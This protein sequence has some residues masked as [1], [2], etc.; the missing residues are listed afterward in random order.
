VHALIQRRLAE[1][2]EKL[3]DLRRVRSTLADG[4]ERCRNP[5]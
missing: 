2:D 4:L 1:V 3:A 5:D